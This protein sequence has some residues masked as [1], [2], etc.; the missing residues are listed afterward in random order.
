MAKAFLVPLTL[1]TAA[2]EPAPTATSSLSIAVNF[3][4]SDSLLAIV[5]ESSNCNKTLLKSSG[6]LID[7]RVN[8]CASF[9]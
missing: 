3:L 7:S 9:K 1:I 5:G 4:Y 8:F 2:S 6:T